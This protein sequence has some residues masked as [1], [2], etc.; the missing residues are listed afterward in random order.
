VFLEIYPFKMVNG[1]LS[2]V[3]TTLLLLQAGYSY[4]PYSSPESVIEHSKEPL[5]PRPAANP[6]HH[7]NQQPN[8]QQWLLFFM[9]TLQ[10]QKRRLFHLGTDFRK[11]T[12]PRPMSHQ[13][14]RT[15]KSAT[16][17]MS[18]SSNSPRKAKKS[19]HWSNGET[20]A[21][22][23]GSKSWDVQQVPAQNPNPDGGSK[24][25]NQLV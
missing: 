8:W 1:Q 24:R 4:V 13:A 19:A 10:Q 23:A 17:I 12:V 3:L 7:P 9:R 20:L 15:T 25:R 5:L 6:R 2:R 14:T 21:S 16:T 18:A 11:K 22:V